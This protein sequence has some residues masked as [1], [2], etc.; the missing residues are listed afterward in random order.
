MQVDPEPDADID[1]LRAD[2]HRLEPLAADFPGA[3]ADL[4]AGKPLKSI[5]RRQKRKPRTSPSGSLRTTS[6]LLASAD[7]N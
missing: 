4:A 1:A 7:H 3:S 6:S 5:S 2:V